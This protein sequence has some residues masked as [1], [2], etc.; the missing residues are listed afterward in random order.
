M[1]ATRNT[2]VILEAG[3]RRGRW[4]VIKEA[5]ARDPY[6]AR[7]YICVCD[8][9]RSREVRAS[10]LKSGQSG[11]CGCTSADAQVTHG[12]SRSRL[13]G[14][15]R[16]MLARTENSRH[17]EYENY[18]GRGIR[19]CDRWHRFELFARDVAQGYERGKQPDRIDNGGNYEPGNCRWISQQAN[20]RNKR[21]NHQVTWRG[22]TLIVQEWAEL[23]GINANTLV[24][25]LK[26]GWSVDRAL[27]KGV[28][29]DVLLEL[30]NG[31]PQ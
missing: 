26:R 23:L 1:N 17:V 9:G 29:A 31:D 28:A 22:R 7:M 19:V 27:S 24:Y 3:S 14:V 10:A 15:W 6:G 16:G 21:T 12:M 11:S 13:Y 30:A 25:R 18:G 5:N 4:T 20:Q 2:A 8:C